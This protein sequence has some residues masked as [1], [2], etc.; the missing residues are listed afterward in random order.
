MQQ[1]THHNRRLRE[2]RKNERKKNKIYSSMEM[3]V[4]EVSC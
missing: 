3:A 4:G 1:S 2:R